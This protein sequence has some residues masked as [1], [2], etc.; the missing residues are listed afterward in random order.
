MN[1]IK[2]MN[3]NETVLIPTKT[4]DPRETFNIN[5]NLPDNWIYNKYNI[6][7]NIVFSITIPTPGGNIFGNFTVFIKRY[8]IVFN[9][10]GGDIRRKLYKSEI[11]ILKKRDFTILRSEEREI[12]TD[13]C[14]YTCFSSSTYDNKNYEYFTNYMIRNSI[15]KDGYIIWIQFSY[16]ARKKKLDKDEYENNISDFS[17]LAELISKTI[18]IQ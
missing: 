8:P 13:I 1:Y 7:D 14:F 2:K 16:G 6:N 11:D 12:N 4:N 5:I 15:Y 18:S 9:F 3:A 10:L 17:K